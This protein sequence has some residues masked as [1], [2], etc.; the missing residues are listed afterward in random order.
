MLTGAKEAASLVAEMRWDSVL[1]LMGREKV[2]GFVGLGMYSYIPTWLDPAG[3]D[4]GVS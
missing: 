2:L 1:A 3:M 4:F